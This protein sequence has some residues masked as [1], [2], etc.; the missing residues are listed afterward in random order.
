MCVYLLAC[1]RLS[2]I[3][4]RRAFNADEINKD[5]KEG[6]VE[7]VRRRE[8]RVTSRLISHPP[9]CQLSKSPS[10]PYPSLASS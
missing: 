9:A 3:N 7:K 10:S 5:R 1:I 4:F 8:E 2:M 6:Q